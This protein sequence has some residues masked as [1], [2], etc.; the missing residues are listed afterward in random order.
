MVE[1]LSVIKHQKVSTNQN[2]LKKMAHFKTLADRGKSVSFS[3]VE[4]TGV[5]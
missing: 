1:L 2:E 5:I 3:E 4:M